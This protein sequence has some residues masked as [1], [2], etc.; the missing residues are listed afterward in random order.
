MLRRFTVVGSQPGGG[1]IY[2]TLG[3]QSATLTRLRKLHNQ[4]AVKVNC[5][6]T[7]ITSYCAALQNGISEST[8]GRYSI[9]NEGQS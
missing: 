6:S 1:S 9:V 7:D 3:P 5:K 4:K 2:P 8:F